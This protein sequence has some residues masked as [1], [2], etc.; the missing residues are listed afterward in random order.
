MMGEC[1][2]G[3]PPLNIDIVIIIIQL[4]DE[5]ARKWRDL[6]LENN[7]PNHQFKLPYCIPHLLIN[8]EF[9][10]TLSRIKSLYYRYLYLFELNIF[11]YS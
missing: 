9:A 3:L 5:F 11:P 6:Y 2:L 4:F 10:K 8:R 7:F 1:S